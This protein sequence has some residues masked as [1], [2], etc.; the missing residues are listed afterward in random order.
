[1]SFPFST[2]DKQMLLETYNLNELGNKLT[3][4][5]DF[6]SPNEKNKNLIN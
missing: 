6:Y 4:L 1:M 2:A 3:S 5:F